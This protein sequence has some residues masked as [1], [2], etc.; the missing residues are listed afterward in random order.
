MTLSGSFSSTVN[1]MLPLDL[2]ASGAGIAPNRPSL[3]LPNG[4][5]DWSNGFNTAAQFSSIYNNVTNN[6]LSSVL[7][8][9]A[10]VNGLSFNASIG[11]NYLTN[12]ELYAVPSTI[13]N[14]LQVPVPGTQATSNLQSLNSSTVNFDPYVDYTRRIGRG[15]LDLTAGASLQNGQTSYT[16]VS[17]QNFVTDALILNPA[18]GIVVTSSYST[19]PNRQLGYFAR[20][21]YIWDQKYVLNLSGR[22]DGST[23]F[24]SNSQYGKFGSVGAAWL[25]SEER[26]VKHNWRFLSFGKLRGSYGTTGGDAI[27]NYQYL[28]NYTVANSGYQGGLAIVPRNIA[29]PNLHW[30]TNTKKEIGL[31]LRF[32]KDRIWLEGS[33]YNNRSSNQLISQPLSIVTGFAGIN[34]NSPALI[35]NE[36]LEGQ[37]T[38]VNIQSK[39]FTW[40]TI[41]NISINRNKL[42]KYPGADA[43]PLILQNSDWIIGKSIQ[44]RKLYKYAGVDPQTGQYA[45]TNAKGVTAPS[46]LPAFAG[47]ADSGG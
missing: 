18:N 42:L 16:G 40:K 11:Y 28:S 12:K 34:Q 17:G 10:P 7:F 1:N 4:K 37:L 25:F 46:S 23:K 35:Q 39:S 19:S 32:L 13:V 45:Y 30:E 26:W 47:T 44:N 14:P 21:N 33:Y 41:F 15:R 3:Y 5:L 22:Y 9:Y 24:G 38:T 31:E 8:R 20:A 6:L 2:S 29:N 43:S 36:G 27:S